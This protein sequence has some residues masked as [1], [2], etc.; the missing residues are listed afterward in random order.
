MSLESNQ[1]IFVYNLTEWSCDPRSKR[2][3]WTGQR[4]KQNPNIPTKKFLLTTIWCDCIHN[5]A[6]IC[7]PLV[8]IVIK[9]DWGSNWY[10]HFY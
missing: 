4:G 3:T 7:K 9:T 5:F 8:C 1:L 2:F 6:K 10:P